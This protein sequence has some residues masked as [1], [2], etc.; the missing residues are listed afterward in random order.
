MEAPAELSQWN[1]VLPIHTRPTCRQSFVSQA[2]DC[3]SVAD[4]HDACMAS[5][6]LQSLAARMS[7][8]DT[9]VTRNRPC[10]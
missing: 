2:K 9:R 1:G 6:V 10:T 3:D 4:A 5:H 7:V 8:F